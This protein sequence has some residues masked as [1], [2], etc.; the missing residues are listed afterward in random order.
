MSGRRRAASDEKGTHICQ[1]TT[2]S[3]FRPASIAAQQTVS[4]SLCLSLILSS[5]LATFRLRRPLKWPLRPAEIRPE[6][7]NRRISAALVS[8]VAAT[9]VFIS[10]RARFVH[11]AGRCCCL[12][13]RELPLVA[14]G[15]RQNDKVA[16]F[17]RPHK[18]SKSKRGR[19]RDAQL[20]WA[21]PLLTHT[22]T[23]RLRG[24]HRPVA[25]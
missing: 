21:G 15:G 25:G 23:A 8:V 12:N 20:H 3:F 1:A 5:S 16:Q 22:H 9:V 4:L 6:R 14:S 13:R 24:H 11:S 17:Q 2:I 10:S 18:S 19:A 7:E